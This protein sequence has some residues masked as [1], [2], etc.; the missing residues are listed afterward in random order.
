MKHATPF[1]LALLAAP[2]AADETRQMGSHVHGIGALNIAADGN[3]IAMEFSAPGA[4]IVGFEHAPESAEDRAAIETAI[5]TLNRP[6][7]LFPLPEAAGC[8]VITASAEL[9]MK[10]HDHDEKHDDHAHGEKHDDDHEHDHDEK[11]DDDHDH[12]HDKHDHDDHAEKHDHDDHDH[13][14]DKAAGHSDF[15]AEYRLS[16]SDPGALTEMGFGYFDAFEN[17][18][19][20]E[21]QIVTSTGARAFDVTREAPSLDLSGLF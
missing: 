11:H 3:E 15:H 2:A 21:V 1:V 17:T 5:A 10:Q 14:H 7:T 8:T 16:C 6:L 18:L 12:T 13:D 9:E 4:D 19:K 20:L